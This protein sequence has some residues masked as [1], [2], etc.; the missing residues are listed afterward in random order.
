MIKINFTALLFI[1][2]SFVHITTMCGQYKA[3]EGVFVS[4]E[5]P[6]VLAIRMV[7]NGVSAYITDG[8]ILEAITCTWQNPT[9]KMVAKNNP[10]AGASFASLDANS[11]VWVTDEQL[12]TVF[13]TRR[14]E[15]IE[16]VWKELEAAYKGTSVNQTPSETNKSPQHHSYANKKFLHLYTGNGYT[17][18]WA[19]YL[20]ENGTFYFRSSSAYS[21]GGY[22]DFSAATAGNDG[23]NY[24]IEKQSGQEYLTLHWNTGNQTKLRITKTDQGYLLDNEKYFLVGLNEYE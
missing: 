6:L 18:K 7:D 24:T 1:F 2:G 10:S 16:A 9:L 11:N 5:P 15:S 13:F 23:G 19:Y 8:S 14:D 3:F 20:Y 12:N 4:E 22:Y 17:E 21:S